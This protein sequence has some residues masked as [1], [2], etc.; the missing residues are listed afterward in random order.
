VI[1][2]DPVR[3]KYSKDAHDLPKDSKGRTVYPDFGLLD[4]GSSTSR[5]LLYKYEGFDENE[6]GHEV[7]MRIKW[8]D[9]GTPG[10]DRMIGGDAECDRMKEDM[11]VLKVD[12]K[13]M[14]LN[15]DMVLSKC[16]EM[17]ERLE[18]KSRLDNDLDR[19]GETLQTKINLQTKETLLKVNAN[20]E[21]RIDKINTRL[22]SRPI[23]TIHYQEGLR[24]RSD[25]GVGSPKASNAARFTP[26]FPD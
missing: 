11:R 12:M 2:T 25:E 6:K 17:L 7:G 3:E 20:L 8:T 1:S 21:M 5:E 9:A 19:L 13:D 23:S 15:V 24:I 18:G 14:K 26:N 16:D 4:E 22:L 10:L